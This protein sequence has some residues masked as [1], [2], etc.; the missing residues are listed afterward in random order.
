LIPT[1][2]CKTKYSRPC[3]NS[4]RLGNGQS[5]SIAFLKAIPTC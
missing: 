2:G 5:Y 3:M 1:N 4:L